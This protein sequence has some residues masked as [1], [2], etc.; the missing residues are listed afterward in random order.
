[1]PKRNHDRESFMQR[2]GASLLARMLWEALT[3]LFDHF[4]A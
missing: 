1:M 4:S 3:G 2:V